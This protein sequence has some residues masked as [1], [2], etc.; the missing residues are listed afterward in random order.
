MRER[1]EK[2]L[3]KKAAKAQAA[4]EKA[5]EA[6][7]KSVVHIRRLERNKRKFVTAVQGMDVHGLELKKV[8]K[9]FGKKVSAPGIS[10]FCP[11]LCL[12]RFLSGELPALRFVC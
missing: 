8:A 6:K 4:D 11:V 1:A 5:A 10:P 2:D 9:E 7:A 3:R 12:H